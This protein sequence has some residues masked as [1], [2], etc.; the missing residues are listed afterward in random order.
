MKTLKK[1]TSLLLALLLVLS[2]A[3]CGNDGGSSGGNV[4]NSDDPEQIV[5]DTTTLNIMILHKGYGFKWL[6]ALK[7]GFEAANPG[8]TVNLTTISKSDIIKGDLKNYKKSDY[9]LYF[10]ISSS[11]MASLVQ[12]YST[13]YAGNQALRPLN[14]VLDSEIPGE[15]ITVREKI[16]DSVLIGYQSEGRDTED[17]ADDVY[18]GL[19][20][21]TGAMGLYYNETVINEALGEGSWEVPNTTD[22]LI[23]LCERLK[24]ADCHMLVPGS[25]DQYAKSFFLANW[26]QYEGIENYLKF[27]DGI[28][29]DSD[30][31]RET[32]KSSLIYQQE[33]RL[34]A[35][36]VA[37]DLL[38]P[39][40]GFVLSNTAEIGVN[41]L[42]DYQKRF[43]DPKNKLAFYFCGDWLM[44]EL[45]DNSGTDGSSSVIKMMKTPVISAIINSTNGY[46]VDK[47][48]RLPSVNDDAT[49]S[50]VVDYVD[51]VSD[52]LPAG[53]T[54]SEVA[55]IQSARNTMGSNNDIHAVYAPAFSNAKTL[56]NDFLIYMASDEG[57]QLF[58]DNCTGGFAP[59]HYE[60]EGLNATEQSIYEAT[61]N[62]TFV[63]DF[64]Y[65]ELF[66]F[67]GAKA[68]LLGISG[69]FDSYITSPVGQFADAEALNQQFL[70]ENSGIKWDA[71][72][73]RIGG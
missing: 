24:A 52:T 73:D 8:V 9:D 59:Y 39:D 68:I 28:G 56:A 49:L 13:Y 54:D 53:V 63:C 7:E 58:K 23:A 37:F 11:G 66:Y 16:Y 55:F 48:A 3:A 20:Y 47:E 12:E 36:K 25:L 19:P 5:E 57:I 43:V 15:G 32:A 2:M 33:G 62:S 21:V 6:E 22:E 29:F 31:G 44:Q 26:A 17:T 41:N 65:N 1:I 46:S 35:M 42:N 30:R 71:L 45:Q 27:F 64:K 60:Y 18:Y 72:V 10:D 4:V 50:A 38:D 69:T 14:D 67:A 40:N 70:D 34:E 61:S 51:G